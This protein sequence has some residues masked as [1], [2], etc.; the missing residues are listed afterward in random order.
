MAKKAK[1]R[2]S[3]RYKHETGE[4]ISTDLTLD[5]SITWALNQLPPEIEKRVALYGLGKVLQDRTSQDAP[6]QKLDRMSKVFNLLTDGKWKSDRKGG[7]LGI[8]PAY[9]EVVAA[10]RGWKGASGIAKAQKAWKATSEE[11]RA[12]LLEL[13]F[14]DIQKVKDAR[15]KAEKVESL[16]DLI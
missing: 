12:T 5:K 13:W 6:D 14:E 11:T 8:V 9:I 4:V 7:G 1:Q 2:F 15:E 3:W 16:D 10:K